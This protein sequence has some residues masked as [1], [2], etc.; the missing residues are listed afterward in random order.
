[1]TALA[2]TTICNMIRMNGFHE[3]KP[4]F[5]DRLCLSVL[6]Y[7][8]ESIQFHRSPEKAKGPLFRKEPSPRSF[9]TRERLI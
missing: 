4:P 1:M 5:S 6:G 9:N 2:A 8:S 3:Y 7:Q